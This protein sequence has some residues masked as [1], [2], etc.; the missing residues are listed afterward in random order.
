MRILYERDDIMLAYGMNGETLPPEQGYPLRLTF[1][2]ITGGVWVQWVT[3]V[4]VTSEQ[5]TGEFYPLP[6]H[7][8]IFTPEHE[9][10]S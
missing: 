6:P 7:C 1:P 5:M 3:H 2:G 10:T 4:E 8:Q 9:Q